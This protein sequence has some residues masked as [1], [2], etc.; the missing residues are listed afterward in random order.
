MRHDGTHDVIVIEVEICRDE[1]GRVYSA[2]N[3][4]GE[5]DG[6]VSMTW[7]GGGQREVAH[8]LLTEALRREAVVSVLV[9]LTQD[10]EYL[11]KLQAMTEEERD[12]EVEK[13]GTALLKSV[14]GTAHRMAK[15]IVQDA[16]ASME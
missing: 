6:T 10:E 15:G 5:G 8:A 4:Q 2:H 14:G 9:R 7:P 16:L 3:L 13:L 1:F 11:A 12:A